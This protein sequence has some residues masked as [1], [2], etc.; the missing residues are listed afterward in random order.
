MMTSSGAESR[1]YR[2]LRFQC[3]RKE[4]NEIMDFH[5]KISSRVYKTPL[6]SFSILKFVYISINVEEKGS[7]I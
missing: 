5:F 4:G 2:W 6:L 1:N 7:L 3:Y